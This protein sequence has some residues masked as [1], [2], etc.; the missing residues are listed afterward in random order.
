MSE[1]FPHPILI[2][3]VA[4]EIDRSEFGSGPPKYEELSLKTKLK[5]HYE[6]GLKNRPKPKLDKLRSPLAPDSTNKLAVPM[7]LFT[8]FASVKI[9]MFDVMPQIYA[10]NDWMVVCQQAIVA[11]LFLEMMINWL[12]IRYVDSSYLRYIR[13]NGEPRFFRKC[14][15]EE[16]MTKDSSS[17]KRLTL[18][19][20]NNNIEQEQSRPNKNNKTTCCSSSNPGQHQQNQD[21]DNDTELANTAMNKRK[22][23]RSSIQDLI[24][25]GKTSSPN[26][27]PDS[28]SAPKP[29]TTTSKGGV[30]TKSY[31][32]WSWVPCYDCGWT[33]PPRCHH[34][35]VCKTCCLKR[36][37]HCFFAGACVGY[38]NFRFFYTFLI[39]AWMGSMYATVH[40]FPYV[41]YFLWQDMSYFD[42]FFPI[43]IVRFILGYVNFQTAVSVT[44]LWLLVYFD[45]L[46]TTFIYTH[47]SLIKWGLTSFEKVFI[48]KTTEI[49]DTRS[50][51]QKI[52]SIFGRHWALG[53][54]LPVNFF[55]EPEEDP[56]EWPDIQVI[57]HKG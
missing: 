16:A 3:P 9:G 28:V 22:D 46:T 21:L 51:H 36:D 32:Y 56:I 57:R 53:F 7:F 8:T 5:D 49:R 17:V 6:K 26:T 45:S 2:E 29:T 43:A 1:T 27:T 44:T 39:W 20:V 38:R 55:Y 54:F 13:V 25:E 23:Q 19:Q 50:L 42:V 52:R 41:G 11:I 30:V 14:K 4:M 40:G 10:G 35:P 31:P 33:R 47:T 15:V 34:C 12:G 48:K 18:N 24:S 37:H